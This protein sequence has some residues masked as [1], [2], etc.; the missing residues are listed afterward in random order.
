MPANGNHEVAYFSMEIALDPA[1]PTYAGGLGILAGDTL[2]S[3]AD[4]GMSMVGVSLVHRKGHFCQQLDS[5]GNQTES[6]ADWGPEERL[7]PMKPVVL[8]TIDGRAVHVR[9]WR[10][11]IKGIDGDVVPV[12][13]LDTDLPENIDEDRRLT[14][15]LYGGDQR[16]RLRQEAI[17]G[18]GGRRVAAQTRPLPHSQLPHE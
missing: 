11:I 16:N 3:A 1:I 9:A 17:L 12:Y 2:R 14:D 13:L 4:L 6:P 15:L 5:S 18:I 7:E 10:W 8:V